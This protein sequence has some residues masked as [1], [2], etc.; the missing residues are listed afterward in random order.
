VISV[1]IEDEDRKH[2]W[3]EDAESVSKICRDYKFFCKVPILLF[4]ETNPTQ[5]FG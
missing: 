1:G 4:F 5:A 3:M 2:T